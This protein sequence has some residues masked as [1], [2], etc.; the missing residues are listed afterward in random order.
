MV[1]HGMALHG[2]YCC[3]IAAVTRGLN[4][5]ASFISG[6]ASSGD[7]GV[8]CLG[9]VKFAVAHGPRRRQSVLIAG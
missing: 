4:N 2:R 3:G 7:L 9:F 8:C 1:R 6:D 5:K